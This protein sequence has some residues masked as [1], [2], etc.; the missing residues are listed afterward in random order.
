MFN[1]ENM[2]KR[3]IKFFPTWSNIRRKY[4][5]SNGGKLLSTIIEETIKTEDAIKEYED[6]YF[7]DKYKNKNDVITFCYKADIGKVKDL[8]FIKVEYMSKELEVTTDINLF[9]KE[10]DLAYYE[11]GRIYVRDIIYVDNHIRITYDSTTILPYTLE[12]HHVW[13]IFDEY[14]CLIGLERHFGETNEQLY[15]RMQFFNGNKVNSSEEGL[16]NAIISELMIIEPELTKEDIKIETLNHTNLHK[17]Y[18]N[19]SS[20]LDKL[21]EIN[22]DIHR[23][24]RWNLHEWNY[25]FVSLEYSPV[26]WDEAISIWQNGIGYGSDLEVKIADDINETDAVITLYEKDTKELLKYVENTDIQKDVE[27]KLTRHNDVLNHVNVAYKI[28]ASKMSKIN[29][30]EFTL[31]ILKQEK[32]LKRINLSEIYSIGKGVISNNGAMLNDTHSYKLRFTPKDNKLEME[33]NRCD[34]TYKDINTGEIIETKKMLDINDNFIFNAQGSLVNNSTKKSIVSTNKMLTVNN[35]INTPNGI[36]IGN[37]GSDGSGTILINDLGGSVFNY[38]LECETVQLPKKYIS[39]NSVD[40]LYRNDTHT[41]IIKNDIEKTKTIYIEVE[42]NKVSFDVLTN[43]TVLVYKYN[44]ETDSW[45]DEEFAGPENTWSTIETPISEKIKLKIVS[46]SLDQVTLGNFKYSNY[47][48]EFTTLYG[49]I[50]K[51]EEGVLVLPNNIS[52]VLTVTMKSKSGLAPILKGIYIGRDVSNLNYTTKTFAPMDNCIRYVNISSNCYVQLLEVNENDEIINIID[53]YNPAIT[54]TAIDND[55]YIKLDLSSFENIVSVTSPTGKISLVEDGNTSYYNLLL[56]IGEKASYI[57]VLASTST[58]TSTI[59]LYDLILKYAPTYDAFVDGLYCSRLIKGLMIA[60]YDDLNN[61]NI[62]QIDNKLFDSIDSVKYSFKEMPNDINVIWGSGNSQVNYGLTHNGD[63]EYIAFYPS[64]SNITTA[65]N[66]YQLYVSDVKG[67]RIVNNFTEEI[68]KNSLYFYIVEPFDINDGLVQIKFYDDKLDTNKDFSKLYNW[69]VGEKQLYIRYNTDLHNLSSYNV[70]EMVIKDSVKLNKYIKIK[71]YY[72]LSN[73]NVIETAKYMITPPEGMEVSFTTYDG[74]SSTSHLLKC[75][76]ITVESDSFKKLNYCNVDKILYIGTSISKEEDKAFNRYT[77][78]KDEGIIIWDDP[79]RDVGTTIYIYYAIKQPTTLILDDDL[80]YK[81]LNYSIS[82]Y[83]ILDE[84]ILKKQKDKQTFDLSQIPYFDKA[85][86][87]HVACS[88]STF[89]AQLENGV[90]TFNKY[91]DNNTIL[92]KPGYYY[93]NGREYYLFNNDNSLDVDTNDDIDYENIDI[94]GDKVITYKE[95][96]NYVRNSAMYLK[97][98]GNLYNYKYTDKRAY[99]MCGFYSLTSCDS[100]NNWHVFGVNLKLATSYTDLNGNNVTLNGTALQFNNCKDFGYAYIDITDYIYEDITYISLIS[101]DV[102]VYLAS[103]VKY[104]GLTF[105]KAIHINPIKEITGSAHIKDISFKR[106]KDTKYY[107][108]VFGEGIIDDIIITNNE[109]ILSSCHDKNIDLLG[110]E[111]YETKSEGAR[112]RMSIGKKDF[113]SY[114]ASLCSD[115]LI[116][117]VSDI[118]WGLTPLKTYT[119]K[120]DFLTCELNNVQLFNDYIR[121]TNKER[122]YLFTSPI[123]ISNPNAI[124]RLF[125]KINNVESK[126]NNDI[127]TI[128]YTSNKK[129]GTYYPIAHINENYGYVDGNKI[130]N[131]IKIKIE[132]AANK[133]VDNIHLFAE[134]ISTAENPLKAPTRHNG[135]LISNVFDA[136]DLLRYRLVNFDISDI[137]NINDVDFYIRSSK[138]KYDTVVWS[139]W[140]KITINNDNNIVNPLVFNEARFFQIKINLSSKDAYV[141]FKYL[142]IEVF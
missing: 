68:E 141:G 85:E 44:Y 57:D 106:E 117:T 61:L 80:L 17:A 16:K 70:S 122:G 38:F 96:N 41:L 25:D 115:G 133:V 116:R 22:A 100:F 52:N 123:Y 2:I 125:F 28:Q 53:D 114:G 6:F 32:A 33:I 126:F 71:D 24:K 51:N 58:S 89:E 34:I 101:A 18:E 134:Y 78:L 91:I 93:I 120:A 45:S 87:V 102:K 26:K 132:M 82:S 62:I 105:P 129:D 59:T 137:S 128:I 99:G 138:G 31:D 29:P 108:L 74:T 135:Y 84:Y 60:K 30:F 55:A 9:F 36:T 49:D 46:D 136:Q 112:Y 56:D 5:T 95:T 92:V 13:N 118:N 107:L 77:L 23:Y 94:T 3:A 10:T 86:L 83:S 63:F 37:N 75:E 64:N 119:T 76:T 130:E 65:I 104:M 14:A 127:K 131:Y 88:E 7:L 11:E 97:G 140:E 35:L 19:Y 42:A 12:L 113:T 67:V 103:E 139:D 124:K 27:L 98:I 121:T 15:K 50:L 111:L 43:N 21:N 81:S 69:T 4:E 1:Y 54:Y 109:N 40:C 47:D 90:I 72:E 73:N 20:L 39:Y 142:E 48:V 8:N 79:I 66:N 110:I